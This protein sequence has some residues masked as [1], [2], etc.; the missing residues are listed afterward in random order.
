MGFLILI[1]FFMGSTNFIRTTSN[2][3]PLLHSDILNSSFHLN[4]SVLHGD[5]KSLPR[6]SQVFLPRD[7]KVRHL[8]IF[9]IHS[10][11]KS[12]VSMTRLIQYSC[13]CLP[14]SGP[15][16]STYLLKG[17]GKHRTQTMAIATAPLK[18]VDPGY[19]LSKGKV[20]YSKSEQMYK[21]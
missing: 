5:L 14:G 7:T 4:M 12:S 8:I 13:L 16:N 19:V 2:S 20:N 18:I 1:N 15:P 11:Y 10:R 6:N 3:V 17:N 9:N 21:D